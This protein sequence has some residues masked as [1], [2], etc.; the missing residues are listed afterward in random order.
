MI[1]IRST[2]NQSFTPSGCKDIGIRKFE[3]MAKTQYVYR[4]KMIAIML[5]AC[6]FIFF[7]IFSQK[8]RLLW[9]NV[10]IIFCISCLTNSTQCVFLFLCVNM[11]KSG[12]KSFVPPSVILVP[13][14]EEKQSRT[15]THIHAHARIV[16]RWLRKHQLS[17]NLKLPRSGR[18][19]GLCMHYLN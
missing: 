19:L 3:F 17:N 7:F 1:S 11:D 14:F 16:W 5:R 12:F 8:V 4:G 2:N 15:I 10:I 13:F 9:K 6:L 18:T